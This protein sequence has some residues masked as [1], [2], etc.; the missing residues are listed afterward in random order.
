MNAPRAHGLRTDA[1]PSLRRIRH[2]PA[3]AM[4]FDL[5]IRAIPAVTHRSWHGCNDT[6]NAFGFTPIRGSNPRASAL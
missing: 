4:L 5:Q 3:C 6:A 1:L 2:N